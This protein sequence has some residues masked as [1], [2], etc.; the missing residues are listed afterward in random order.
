MPIC[1]KCN[2]R[3][4]NRTNIDGRKVNLSSRKYCLDCSPYGKHNTIPIH[5]REYEH[6]TL[7][8][9]TVG[10]I[11]VCNICRREYEFSKFKGHTKN[12]CNS[13]SV[14]ERRFKLK[15]KMC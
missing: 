15:D 9:Q 8:E 12:K 4:P 13:C 14:N 10:D 1:K 3:F 6:I 2:S 7:N 11:C 5:L